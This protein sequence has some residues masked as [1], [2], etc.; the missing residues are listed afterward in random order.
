MTTL[1]L[2]L[3]ML[4]LRV[5]ATSSVA[6]ALCCPLLENPSPRS[7]T[8]NQ[9]SNATLMSKITCSHRADEF[10]SDS[11]GGYSLDAAGVVHGNAG[12]AG[13]GGVCV[14]AAAVAAASA[15]AAVH[16]RAAVA[17]EH[18]RRPRACASLLTAPYHFSLTIQHIPT[19]LFVTVTSYAC[20]QA[21]HTLASD[22]MPS[23]DAR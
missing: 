3:M 14:R 22:R 2:R 8:F 6:W 19:Y 12:G 17:L 13:V 11:G 7:P 9:F 18:G 16:T 10:R 4:R 5:A 23:F 20:K 15:A 21:S 1:C